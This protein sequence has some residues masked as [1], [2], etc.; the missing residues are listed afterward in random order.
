MSALWLYALAGLGWTN[1]WP[2]LLLVVGV[3]WGS[4]NRLRPAI[5]VGE[6]IA[7]LLLESMLARLLP[8]ARTASLAVDLGWEGAALAGFALLGGAIGGIF[9][10]QLA[11]GVDASRRAQ[12]LLTDMR[13]R[14]VV[15]TIRVL[16]AVLVV[17]VR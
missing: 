17:A 12:R 7:A 2:W 13:R 8:K 3:A 5:F 15:R 11:F 10:W 1:D 9:L 14:L 4:G 6:L 16:A